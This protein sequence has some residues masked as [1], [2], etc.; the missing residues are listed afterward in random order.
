MQK[1]ESTYT[2]HIT[3]E[4]IICRYNYKRIEKLCNNPDVIVIILKRNKTAM[5]T[6]PLPLLLEKSRI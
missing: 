6:T 4:A 2:V 5:S 3:F 1:L